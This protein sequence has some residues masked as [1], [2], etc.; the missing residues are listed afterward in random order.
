[1]AIGESGYTATRRQAWI[2]VLL[3]SASLA[4][5]AWFGTLHQSVSE[6]HAYARC[7]SSASSCARPSS[8]PLWVFAVLAGLFVLGA[9]A[10][11]LRREHRTR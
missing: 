8:E 7:A 6:R 4:G 3:L 2:G 5:A 11:A 10:V 1:M 9:V